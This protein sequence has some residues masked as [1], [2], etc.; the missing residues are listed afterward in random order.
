MTTTPLDEL[1]QR[2]QRLVVRLA[3]VNLAMLRWDECAANA[4]LPPD[5]RRVVEPPRLSPAV[6]RGLRAM[7]IGELHELEE[8]SD[9]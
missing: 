7:P 6:L 5:L 8:H 9:A 2:R 4:T 1:E 3:R